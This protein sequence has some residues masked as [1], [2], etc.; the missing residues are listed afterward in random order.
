MSHSS[1]AGPFT[2]LR[3]YVGALDAAD[4]LL[5]IP[6]FDQDRFESTAFA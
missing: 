6:E 1:I 2:S 5:H 3:D 4:L